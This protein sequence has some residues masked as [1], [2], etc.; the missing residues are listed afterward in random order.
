MM[1]LREVTIVSKSKLRL[2]SMAAVSMLLSSCASSTPKMTGV[3][4]LKMV[5]A[6]ALPTPT[7]AD[8]S[9]SERPYRV[10]AFDKLTI[11]VFGSEE[12]SKKEVQVD[13]SGRMTFPLIGTIEVAGKTP[14]EI[15]EAMQDQF[16]GRYIRNPQV[17]VSLK[18]IVSQTVTIGGEVKKA[19]VY[20]IVGKMTLLTAIASAEGWTDVSSRSEVVVFRTVNSQDYAAIYNV[21]A[22]QKGRYPDPEVFASDIIMVGESQSRKIWKDFL[23]ASP[24]LAPVIYLLGQ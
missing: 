20:P 7:I 6:S 10:G 3:A 17:T 4:D 5:S 24:L 12:L 23:G 22:I 14:G 15:G 18:E 2:A 19:G 16:R 21:K 1:K 11:D 13:A 9:A 8:M